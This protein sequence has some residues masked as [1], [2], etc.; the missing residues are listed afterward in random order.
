MTE[1]AARGIVSDDHP[2]CFGFFDMSQHTAANL[3]KES[4]AVLFL[5]KMLDFTIGYG[6]PPIIPSSARVI[7]VEP[8]PL[9]IGRN[10]AVDV[11]IVGDVGPVVRQMTSCARDFKWR[12]T[13]WLDRFRDANIAQLKRLDDL[14]QGMEPMSSMDVHKQ[15]RCILREDDILVFDGGDYAY[16]GRATLPARSPNS[17]YYLPNLGMLG[18]ALPVAIAAK[19]AKPTSRVFCITG[20]GA[21]GFNAIEMDTAVRHQI[22]I[23]VLLGNDAAWGIDKNIQVGLYGKPVIT[24]LAPSRYD[25]VAQ[26]LGAYG[27]LVTKPEGLIPAIERAIASKQPSLLNIMVHSM[28]SPRAQAL[29]DSRKSG[30]AF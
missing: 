14:A 18:Q 15:L 23:I 2:Y 5:G 13:V 22:P 24:D 28:I 30:G 7:Q 17:W 19:I 4:D 20:D 26:G 11:G 8:E 27:E 9:Q 21:F 1:E 29:V 12:E 3:I 25:I 16:Y 6:F 10:R